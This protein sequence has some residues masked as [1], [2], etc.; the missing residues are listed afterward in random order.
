M[1]HILVI[2]IILPIFLAAI[3]LVF[4]I[5][6]FLLYICSMFI[7]LFGVLLAT[8][9]YFNGPIS[10]SIG[11][12]T[13]PLGITLYMDGLSA[14]MI[15]TLSFVLSF[16]S[17]YLVSYLKAEKFDIKSQSYIISAWLFMWGSLNAL[18]LSRDLFNLYVTLELVGLTSVILIAIA[19]TENALRASLR[20]FILAMFGSL[21]YLFGVVMVYRSLGVLDL[22]LISEAVDMKN[23]DFQ[24]QIGFFF[25]LLGLFIKGA[26]FPFH[27]WLPPAHANA[28]SPISALLSAVVV[29]APFYLCVR[30]ITISGQNILDMLMMLPLLIFA[31]C[32]IF[33]GSFLALRQ[34]NL[35]MLI[36]Y[37]TV[38]QLGYLY[39]MLYFVADMKSL[40]INTYKNAFAGV[41]YY[42]I[43]HM[44]AKAAL[45]MSAGNMVY[46]SETHRISEIKNYKIFIPITIFAFGASSISIMSMPPTGGFVGKWMMLFASLNSQHWVVF[47]VILSGSILSLSYLFRAFKMFFVE[48]DENLIEIRPIPF[49]MELSALSLGVIVIFM[50]FLSYYPLQ[51][52][53]KWTLF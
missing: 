16:L 43:S 38:A 2:L 9:V 41:I 29:K 47:F 48:S 53:L 5:S 3:S 20:Y 11:D 30:I 40:D 31:I 34:N 10:F 35:K 45:F 44:V 7:P 42:C 19:K 15:L 52:L 26:I 25:I 28:L 12:W 1:I 13:A 8:Y 27:F 33:W 51:L 24:L 37:S 4:K 23:L 32:A 17:V 49:T 21:T 14:L 18:F 6:P 46:A 39:I 22:I 50:G 36:A